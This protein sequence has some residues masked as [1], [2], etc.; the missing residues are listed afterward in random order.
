MRR[1]LLS[2]ATAACLSLSGCISGRIYTHTIV[3]YD[4]NLRD[5]N[6]GTTTASSDS[7]DFNYSY[8]RIVWGDYG[9]ADAAKAAG[10]SE[11]YFADLETLSVLGIWTQQWI[12]VYGK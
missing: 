4:T 7:K 12:L 10:L 5:T 9:I 6:A 11:V 2:A 3:P 8:V 1:L